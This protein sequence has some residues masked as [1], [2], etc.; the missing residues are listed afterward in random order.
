M[1]KS[2]QTLKQYIEK[3][4]LN[5]RAV[6]D[7]HRWCNQLHAN[8]ISDQWY[9]WQYIKTLR[10]CEYHINNNGLHHKLLGLWYLHKLRKLSRITT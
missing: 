4:S 5:Y 2:K 9:I 1:I 7:H 10:M 3:D 6:I 8:P